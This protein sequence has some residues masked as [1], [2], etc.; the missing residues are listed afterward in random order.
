MPKLFET[1]FEFFLS[2]IYDSEHVP[3][4][5]YGDEERTPFKLHMELRLLKER[6][7]SARSFLNVVIKFSVLVDKNHLHVVDHLSHDTY[8]P[9]CKKNV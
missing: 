8:Y 9:S 3:D 7:T 1:K 6:A 2:V 4:H 5:L